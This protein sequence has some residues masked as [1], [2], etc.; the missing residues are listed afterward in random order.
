MPIATWHTNLST[1][2]APVDR[3]T[4]INHEGCKWSASTSSAILF[5]K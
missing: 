4:P 2:A 5:F 1:F 3:E